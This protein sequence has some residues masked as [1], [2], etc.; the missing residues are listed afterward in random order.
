[1]QPIFWNGIGGNGRYAHSFSDLLHFPIKDW[2][3][4]VLGFFEI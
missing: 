1:M 2:I 4:N 3:I